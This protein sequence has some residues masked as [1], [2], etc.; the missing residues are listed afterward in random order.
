AASSL[1]RYFGISA[2]ETFD[3]EQY[4]QSSGHSPLLAFLSEYNWTSFPQY[5]WRTRYVAA[6]SAGS[7]TSGQFK[8]ARPCSAVSDSPP[9]IRDARTSHCRCTVVESSTFIWSLRESILVMRTIVTKLESGN[10]N[11]RDHP[12]WRRLRNARDLLCIARQPQG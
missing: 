6:R 1:N 9:N 3:C 2:V 10:Q 7:S 12:Y 5:R 11:H 8:I 4:P